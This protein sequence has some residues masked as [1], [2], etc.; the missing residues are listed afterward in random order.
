MKPERLRFDVFGRRID[1]ERKKGAWVAYVPGNDG[2]R[3]PAN[4]PI[5]SELDPE[6]IAKYFGDLFH[7]SANSKHPSVRLL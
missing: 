7:E 5:E 6:G 1:V 2:T 3:R 4:I